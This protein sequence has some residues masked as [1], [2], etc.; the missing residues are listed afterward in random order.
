M[1]LTG[2]EREVLSR[3]RAG[4]PTK[5]IASELGVSQQAVKAHIAH[6]FGKFDAANRA[7]LVA[8]SVGRD[9]DATARRMNGLRRA[10][11]DLRAANSDLRARD[12][13]RDRAD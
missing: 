12:G 7:G 13:A 3:V 10:N 6:L 5:R 11:R 4:Q 8:R 9:R 1:D 2:R